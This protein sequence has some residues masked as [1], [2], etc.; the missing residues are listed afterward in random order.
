MSF[1]WLLFVYVNSIEFSL[2][3][4]YP[5][6]SLNSFIKLVIH[7]LGFSKYAVLSSTHSFISSFPI[8]LLFSFVYIGSEPC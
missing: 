7:S 3:I 5:A 6:T 4:L 1:N 2:L 8:L